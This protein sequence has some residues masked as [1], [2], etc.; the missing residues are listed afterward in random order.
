ML[1]EENKQKLIITNAIT[2]NNNLLHA[3]IISCR[4]QLEAETR[5]RHLLITEYRNIVVSCDGISVDYFL[6]FFSSHIFK[7][8]NEQ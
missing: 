6:F 1:S 3:V 7:I 8:S 2:R 5:P 4:K